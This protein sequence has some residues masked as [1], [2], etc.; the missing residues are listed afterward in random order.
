MK[1]DPQHN[2]THHLDILK[3]THAGISKQNIA[4]ASFKHLTFYE[5]ISLFVLT[6]PKKTKSTHL[7]LCNSKCL[8]EKIPVHTFIVLL[9]MKG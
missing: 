7:T 4:K 3:S 9:P 2:M 5:R 1:E 6:V 8:F